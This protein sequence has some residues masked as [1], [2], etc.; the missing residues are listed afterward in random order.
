MEKD[1]TMIDFQKKLFELRDA[2]YAA[3]Q[4]KLTPTVPAELFIG[5]R[6]PQ[7]RALAKE[8][9]KTAQSKT[10][11]AKS[12]QTAIDKFLNHL[13]HK[14]YDEN[15]LHGLLVAEIKDFD[16]CVEVTDKFLPYVDNWA[17][18]DIMSPKVFKKNKEKLLEKIREWAASSEVYTSRFGVEMLQSHFL[19]EGFK[20]EYLKIPAAVKGEDYYIKMMV[21]WF[22]A[23][24]LAKQWEAT[25]PYIEKKKL[26]P[27]THNKTIQKAIES[28]RIT[29]EQKTY[30]RTLK[31]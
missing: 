3:F 1:L 8:I 19:D 31:I 22:F 23:T 21:A 5:V 4:S 6:V 18:C 26:A 24:S 2:E 29:D 27:W 13:P 9:M 12:M 10:A 14:Y 7:V 25:I 17:V 11:E 15:M 20:P 16:K 30:L 28:Y